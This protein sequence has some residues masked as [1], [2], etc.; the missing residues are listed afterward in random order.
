MFKVGDTV[1]YSSLESGTVA[2][3]TNSQSPKGDWTL[4]QFEDGKWWC[5]TW[6]LS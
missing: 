6:T 5:P 4:V 3:D 2:D 1:V